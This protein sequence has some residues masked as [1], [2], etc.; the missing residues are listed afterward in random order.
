MAAG[1]PAPRRRAVVI[2]R[3][4][5]SSVL[6]EYP[7]VGRATVRIRGKSDLGPIVISEPIPADFDRVIRDLVNRH[8]CQAIS[9]PSPQ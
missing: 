2:V 4:E 6:I 8:A 5:V 3:A 1:A 7:G 9:G